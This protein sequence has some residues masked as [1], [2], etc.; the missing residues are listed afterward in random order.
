MRKIKN[1]FLICLLFFLSIACKDK[2]GIKKN[3]YLKS[4]ATFTIETMDNDEMLNSK[5]AFSDSI[6]L[7]KSNS[8][9]HTSH[10]IADSSVM[11]FLKGNKISTKEKFS[12]L[13]KKLNL[14]TYSIDSILFPE[15]DVKLD[16]VIR[17]SK[18]GD[19]FK[20]YNEKN[21]IEKTFL[22]ITNTNGTSKIF[23]SDTKKGTPTF[24]LQDITG[25]GKEELFF[26]QW[27]LGYWGNTY[28]F[29]IFE[30]E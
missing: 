16:N 25:D 7:V 13:K 18:K 10:T 5:L 3:S 21:N 26:A 14:N 24:F 27:N 11:F 28:Y 9:N 20:M 30:I 8:Y 15:T 29:K 12:V 19:I 22:E 17:K 1:P 4:L 6:L 2:K 23:I